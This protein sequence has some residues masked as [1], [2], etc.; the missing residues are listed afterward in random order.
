MIAS[1]GTSAEI[2]PQQAHRAQNQPGRAEAEVVGVA[3]YVTPSRDEP[4]MSHADRVPAVRRGPCEVGR[5]ARPARRPG[6][7]GASRWRRLRAPHWIPATGARE[8]PPAPGRLR[9]ARDLPRSGPRP[10]RP[11]PRPPCLR[12]ARAARLPRLRDSGSRVGHHR[13]S[14]TIT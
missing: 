10:E 13:L 8:D 3:A 14:T 2:P 11:G 6:D 12:R 4:G 7:L 5:R 1:Y 9:A